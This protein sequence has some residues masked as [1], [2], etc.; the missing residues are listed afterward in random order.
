MN[1]NLKV[2]EIIRENDV[3]GGLGKSMIDFLSVSTKESPYL[4][5]KKTLDTSKNSAFPEIAKD[6][7]AFSN[8]G[9]GWILLG[10]EEYKKNQFVPVGLPEEFELEQ[11]VLQEK[12]NSFVR[13]PIHI[14]YR[15]FNKNFKVLFPSDKDEFRNKVNSISDRFGVIFIPPSN[16]ILTPIKIGAYKLQERMRTVFQ[17]GDVFYRRGTQSIN[18]KKNEIDRIKKR[19]KQEDYRLSILSGEPDE[20]EETIYS[21]LFEIINV[22]KFVYAGVSKGYDNVSIKTL[23]KQEKI[24]P[25][26]YFKFKEWGNKIV[27]FENLLDPNNPYQKLVNP[28]SVT[29]Q[30]LRG[31]LK[32]ENKHRIIK[33][34]LNREV[35][36]HAIKE[37]LWL[38]YERNK[39]YYP[40][41]SEESKRKKQW[42]SRYSTPTKTV[43][44]KWYFQ[45][46]KRMFFQHAAFEVE[47]IEF[48][49][50]F[51]LRVLPS[52]VITEDGVR[53]LHNSAIGTLIT[54][55]S[56]KNYNSNYLNNV[57]FWIYQF[58]QGKDIEISSYLTI[59]NKP[60]E[61]KTNYGISHDIPSTESKIQADRKN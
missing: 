8:Q 22:P 31:W 38:S 30:P 42:K 54:T 58:G 36:H 27:T 21:N 12:F 43:A 6:V 39:L 45:K 2:I 41:S 10:W 29:K 26:F 50:T 40:Y 52:I 32:D 46:L 13:N 28:E 5:F 14:G 23:L 57:L 34:I 56:Y 44:S 59:S 55:L 60:V 16:E 53:S 37:G 51:Y 61:L 7:F 1:S 15:E 11:A 33:E 18:A 49:E 19:I 35:K 9:G 4:D 48:E 3:E 47:I 24:F 20:I 25:E 17:S